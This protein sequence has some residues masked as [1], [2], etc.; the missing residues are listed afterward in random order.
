[1]A[2]PPR[3]RPEG[4]DL[5]AD[6]EVYNRRVRGRR[7]RANHPPK[8]NSRD[9]GCDNPRNVELSRSRQRLERGQGG[10]ILDRDSGPIPPYEELR[11]GTSLARYPGTY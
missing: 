2:P 11:H 6:G 3:D 8:E 1:M 9:P 4:G 5:R 7:D 10:R